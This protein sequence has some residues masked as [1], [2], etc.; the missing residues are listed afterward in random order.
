MNSETRVICRPGGSELG[1]A[2]RRLLHYMRAS[3]AYA[4]CMHACVSTHAYA[5]LWW[6]C[7][8]YRSILKLWARTFLR[9][10]WG[11]L[12]LVK[13]LWMVGKKNR[14]L[15]LGVEESFFTY[16]AL[17][18]LGW[19]GHSPTSPIAHSSPEL[20]WFCNKQQS[21]SFFLNYTHRRL[22]QEH[23]LVMETGP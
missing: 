9:P 13:R 19:G 15:G 20:H 17:W 1:M 11:K 14:R 16:C 5:R 6:Q 21:F 2:G 8:S 23:W 4:V 18:I 3:S 12:N 22:E 7:P 10:F